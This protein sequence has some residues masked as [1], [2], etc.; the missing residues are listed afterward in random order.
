MS[1]LLIGNTPPLR[2][3]RRVV[4]ELRTV[5]APWPVCHHPFPQWRHSRTQRGRA[6]PMRPTQCF[7]QGAPRGRPAP[8][9][10]EVVH[11]Q[12]SKGHLLGNVGWVLRTHT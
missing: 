9:C 4:C 12:V 1:K 5:S 3:R 2:S 7:H 10:G 6:N 11:L 8:L